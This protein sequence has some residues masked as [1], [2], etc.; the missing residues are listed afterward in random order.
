MNKVL[1]LLILFISACASKPFHPVS[2]MTFDQVNNMSALS[3]N[4]YLTFVGSE[5]KYLVY[6]TN[7]DILNNQTNPN[8]VFKKY[9]FLNGVFIDTKIPVENLNLTSQQ[10]NPTQQTLINPKANSLISSS[11]EPSLK[12][13]A[14]KI[15]KSEHLS[16]KD[17]AL[18]RNSIVYLHCTSPDAFA[19][20]PS[21]IFF[22][23][24]KVI[25]N[26]SLGDK[27]SL[28]DVEFGDAFNSYLSE[29]IEQKKNWFSKY[30]Q[31]KNVVTWITDGDF[32]NEYHVDTKKLYRKIDSKLILTYD[33]EIKSVK[34]S[35]N[36]NISA[37]GLVN[38]ESIN[39]SLTATQ[40]KIINVINKYANS[41]LL[42]KNQIQE[43][44]QRDERK[45]ELSNLVSGYY[46]NDWV[47]TI[48][49]MSTD[50][51]GDAS[52]NVDIGSNVTLL[53]SN[54]KKGSQLYNVLFNLIPNQKIKFSGSFA[55]SEKDY[56]KEYSI[57]IRGSMT[58]PDF[59]FEFQSIAPI[60]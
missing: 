40:N 36:E 44:V 57:T 10:S 16:E 32:Q 2:G 18:L 11:N 20:Y 6:M 30:T 38:Q 27:Y 34:K 43:S 1:L 9:Y 37:S 58:A 55:P 25:D 28:T 31:N 56:F 47:G 29:D 17:A 35:G 60:N 48:K 42:A 7:R 41:F 59:K 53:S 12:E 22:Y 8:N 4:G 46:I 15:Y 24:G 14:I 51:N 45:A 5:G 3:V 49:Y 52:L 54:I 33:C 39:T 21:N 19:F 23:Q 13:Q 50:A 26:K